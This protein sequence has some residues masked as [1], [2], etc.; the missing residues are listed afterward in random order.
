MRDW[1]VKLKGHAFDLEELSDHFRSPER[2]VRKDDDGHYHLR[3][4]D[5]DLMADSEAV[6]ERALEL[7]ELMN[8]AAKFHAGNGYQPVE[9]DVVAWIDEDGNRMQTV[10]SSVQIGGRSRVSVKPTVITEGESAD[11]PHPPSEVESM[12][13][14]AERD[15]RVADALRYFDGDDW[16]NLY[17]AWEVV[18]DAAGGEHILLRNSWTTKKAKNRFTQTAQSRKALGDE[19]RHASEKYEAPKNPMT[20]DEARAFVKSMMETWVKTL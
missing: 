12:F 14:L 19:A 6:R 7:V 5:F 15:A 1:S 10:T 16:V 18:R 3:S 2:N 8:R 20:L 17:K 13:A 11:A 9:V 4:S